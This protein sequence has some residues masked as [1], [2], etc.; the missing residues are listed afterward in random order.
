MAVRRERVVLD[1]EDN[2]SRKMAEAAAATEVLKR[3]LNSLSGNATRSH[4]PLTTTASDLDR[5]GKS[6]QRNGAEIDRMSGRM[7]IFADVAAMFGPSLVPIGAAG[8]GA[9]AGFTNQLGMAATAPAS[10]C[11]HST[12]SVTRCLP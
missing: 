10:Q 7:R 2:F 1:L 11:S 6:A 5:L 3:E 4:R 8:I 9:L 12:A